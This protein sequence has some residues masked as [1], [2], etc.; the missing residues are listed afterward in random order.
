MNIAG[1]DQEHGYYLNVG[2]SWKPVKNA[3][4]EKSATV[5][6]WEYEKDR[7]QIVRATVGA[8][9]ITVRGDAATGQD[10][11]VGL[12]R[13]LDKAYQITRD[14]ESRTDLYISDTAVND[15]LHPVAT[16]NRW[17]NELRNYDKT[18]LKNLEQA[19]NVVNVL[20]NRFERLQGRQLDAGAVAIGGVKLAEDTYEA[21][22]MANFKPDEAKALMRTPSFQQE[23]LA[24]LNQIEHVFD[25]HEESTNELARLWGAMELDPTSITERRGPVQM[26]LTYSSQINEY[27]DADP[28]RGQKLAL[29]LAMI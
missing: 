3:K 24:R 28:E 2:G 19:G 15:A 26:A 4:D 14:H 20:V 12:N 29:A 13:D 22:L 16:V 27:L 8:G 17:S 11:T 18:A 7:E 25:K 6:G 21:L 1:K 5:S 23:V 9:D 10:S